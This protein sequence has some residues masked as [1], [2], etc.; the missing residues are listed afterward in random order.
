IMERNRVYAWLESL[1]LAVKSPQK[2]VPAP[3]FELRE[4]LL[5]RFL[6]ALFSGDGGISVSGEGIPLEFCSTS[7]RLARDVHHLL[8]RF[9]VVAMLRHRDTVSG[10]GAWLL[11]LTSKDEI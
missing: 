8:L 7:E 3:V 6:R 2:F 10:R 4:P 9:G 11:T 5:A 1:G